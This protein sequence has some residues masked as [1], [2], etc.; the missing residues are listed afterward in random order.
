[1]QS[2]PCSHPDTYRN[3][4]GAMTCLKCGAVLVKEGDD[5]D[6]NDVNND[7]TETQIV[8]GDDDTIETRGGL[9]LETESPLSPTDIQDLVYGTG[10]HYPVDDCPQ[11]GSPGSGA[12]WITSDQ[13]QAAARCLNC[14]NRWRVD[15]E[16]GE[17]IESGADV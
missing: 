14:L 16:T 1:M 13:E 6:D 2:D 11:C 10:P 8:P 7:E 3:G 4:F 9:S 5:D 12:F 17:R 15:P